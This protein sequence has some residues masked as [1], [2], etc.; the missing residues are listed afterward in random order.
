VA[1]PGWATSLTPVARHKRALRFY[2]E[3]L[4]DGSIAQKMRCTKTTV[5]LWRKKH[6]LPSRHLSKPEGSAAGPAT[7]RLLYAQGLCDVDIAAR[8]GAA[9]QTV[10]VWRHR[11]GLPANLPWGS[12]Q[13]RRFELLPDAVAAQGLYRRLYSDE[14][15]AAQL[16]AS[17]KA[18]RRW[19]RDHRLSAHPPG[20][21]GTTASAAPA[22]RDPL[23]ARIAAALGRWLTPDQ[24]DDAIQNLYVAVLLG[25]VREDQIEAKA[26]R[27]GQAVVNDFASRWGPRSMDEKLTDEGLTLAELLADPSATFEMEEALERGWA[28]L[29][30]ANDS[31]TLQP[32]PPH[33]R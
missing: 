32:P 3:G 22:Y 26:A 9:R 30:P 17:V 33:R 25:E 6:G 14:A 20:A 5:K 8:A 13:K 16:R 27:Y 15:M 2:E 19:R 11:Q 12:N 23:F 28:A 7:Y 18:V 1:D 31:E 10:F 29:M 21:M 24:K 4:T